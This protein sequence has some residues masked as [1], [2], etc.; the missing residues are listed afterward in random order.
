MVRTAGITPL[1]SDVLGIPFNGIRKQNKCGID[2]WE[3]KTELPVFISDTI[4][5]LEYL[6]ESIEKHTELENQP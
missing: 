3:K 6:R 4:F 1:L 2:I 5:Y